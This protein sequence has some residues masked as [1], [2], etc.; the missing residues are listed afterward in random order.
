MFTNSMGYD[1]GSRPIKRPRNVSVGESAPLNA[2]PVEDMSMGPM[3]TAD[4]NL[5]NIMM[6][7]EAHH[8]P[9]TSATPNRGRIDDKNNRKLSCKECRR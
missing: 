7:P 5:R 4:D 9:S 2:G 1:Q 3:S 8:I 6:K